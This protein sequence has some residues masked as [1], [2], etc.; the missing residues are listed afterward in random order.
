MTWRCRCIEKAHP[1]VNGND[2]EVW[3]GARFVIRIATDQKQRSP[4]E[5]KPAR[6]GAKSLAKVTP[7]K[8]DA[9]LSV[10]GAGGGVLPGRDAGSS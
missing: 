10:A 1:F 6:D 3:D 7:L 2:V 5:K 4:K 8:I 9:E